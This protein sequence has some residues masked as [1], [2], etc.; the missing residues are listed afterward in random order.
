MLFDTHS[1]RYLIFPMLSIYVLWDFNRKTKQWKHENVRKLLIGI[2]VFIVLVA[3]FATYGL[4]QL[5]NDIPDTQIGSSFSV[6]IPKSTLFYLPALFLLL[7]CL[8]MSQR[9][10]VENKSYSMMKATAIAIIPYTIL[11]YVL[12]WI[13]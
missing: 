6:S 8:G 9:W 2:F 1:I 7:V 10:L 12:G 3:L 11:Y 4:P 13:F 5:Y